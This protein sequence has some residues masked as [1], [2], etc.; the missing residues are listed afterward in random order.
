MSRFDKYKKGIELELDGEK[1]SFKPIGTDSLDDFFI[2]AKAF[3]GL[4]DKATG[5]DFL[6]SVDSPTVKAI[7][8]MLELTLS[9]S[10]PTEWAEDSDSVKSFGMQHFMEILPSVMELN[11]PK[12]TVSKQEKVMER[13]NAGH[14]K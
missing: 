12:K 9:K 1:Y 6:K 8:N 11:G 4:S 3:Q 5:D 10:F 14:K 13:L 2:V 7:Q